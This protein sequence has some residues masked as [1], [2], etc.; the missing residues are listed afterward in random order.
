MT[1]QKKARVDE[2]RNRKRLDEAA[3]TSRFLGAQRVADA[4][5]K[6]MIAGLVYEA[7]RYIAAARKN[8]GFF[9]EPLVLDA[10]DNVLAVVNVWKKSENEAAA[11][12]YLRMEGTAGSVVI[13]IE[14][15]EAGNEEMR[16]RTMRI[17]RESLR[18]FILKNGIHDAGDPDAA[19]TALEETL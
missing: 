3:N 1:G 9:Y 8:D 12:K 14:K 11:G 18:V 2:E 15:G 6:K 10:L 19:M 7:D 17:I 13:P 4:E 5:I 16:E